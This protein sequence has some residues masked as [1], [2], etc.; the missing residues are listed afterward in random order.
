[1]TRSAPA[2]GWI[3]LIAGAVILALAIGSVAIGVSSFVVPF[4]TGYGWSRTTSGADEAV[5]QPI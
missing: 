3:V 2:H 4:E 5:P 1:M